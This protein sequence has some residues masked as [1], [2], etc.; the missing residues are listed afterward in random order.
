MTKSNLI[1]SYAGK[2]QT[3]LNVKNRRK[4]STSNEIF[5]CPVSKL[6]FDDEY[7][8]I[9]KQMPAKVTRIAEHMRLYGYDNS[10]PIIIS[11]DYRILDGYSRYDALMALNGLIKNVPV[12]IKDF[13]TRDEYIKYILHLQMD[14]R[15]SS[16]RDKYH[17]FLHYMELRQHAKE[18]GADTS[19]FSE[20]NLANKLSVSKRQ[21]S[22]LKEIAKKI[23]P[24]L[25]EKLE[26]ETYSLSQIYSL[27]KKSERAAVGPESSS[28]SR[29]NLE[30]VLIGAKLAILLT[31]KGVSPHDIL[32]EPRIASGTKT[33]EFTEEEIKTINGLVS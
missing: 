1:N 13:E 20:E 17:S 21:I 24:D 16:D 29:I 2:L 25:L 6:R 26:S 10:Q 8:K 3:F 31:A 7:K 14:R 27:I 4:S 18:S 22:M 9:Y 11:P 33:F 5:T 30:S 12:I 28:S 19:E 23:T 32:N 15:S